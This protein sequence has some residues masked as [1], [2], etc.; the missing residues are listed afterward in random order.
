LDVWDKLFKRNKNKFNDK[1]FN[2]IS[3]WKHSYKPEYDIC[4]GLI[5]NLKIA[6]KGGKKLNYKGHQA[7]P[8]K[9]EEFTKYLASITEPIE[10]DYYKW[11][12]SEFIT[13]TKLQKYVDIL[14]AEI[15]G[16]SKKGK[17]LL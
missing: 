9:Y 1:I 13:K 8:L 6:L 5:W 10:E 12:Y 7:F 11:D 14:K 17:N 2:F 3:E 16:K 15:I 4:D